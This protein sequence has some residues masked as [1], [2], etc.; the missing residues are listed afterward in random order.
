MRKFKHKQTGKI[1]TLKENGT[2]ISGFNFC[3]PNWLVENSND[4]EE[5]F[6]YPEVF[7]VG[8]IVRDNNGEDWVKNPYSKWECN[9][10]SI[11]YEKRITDSYV[12]DK[13]WKI[14]SLPEKIDYPVGTK[15][16]DTIFTT[17]YIKTNCGWKLLDAINSDEKFDES[18]IGEGKRFQLLENESLGMS[19]ISKT[20][21]GSFCTPLGITQQQLDYQEF[22]R[23]AKEKELYKEGDASSILSLLNKFDINFFIPLNQGEIKSNQE[24]MRKALEKIKAYKEE[25]KWRI[26]TF[27]LIGKIGH[28]KIGDLILLNPHN[29]YYSWEDDQLLYQGCQ[30]ADIFLKDKNWEIYS[31]EVLQDGKCL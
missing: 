31:V 23:I 30:G 13:K 11:K 1:A 19:T 9:Y 29:G 24:R 27:R 10:Y 14:I 28:H 3:L 4:W 6:D 22:L 15:I 12:K 26:T 25:P 2:T 17:R 7:P 20:T 16:R 8:S 21:T 18:Q 5:I